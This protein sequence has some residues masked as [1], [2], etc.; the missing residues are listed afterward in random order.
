M[1]GESM[2]GRERQQT[3]ID[4]CMQGEST[5]GRERQQR[6]IDT[7]MQG[8]STQI[9]EPASIANKIHPGIEN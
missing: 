9:V 5:Q 3:A 7:C 8:E 2:Q 1:Q 4:T 6:A